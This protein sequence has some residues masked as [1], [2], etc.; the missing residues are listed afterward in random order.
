MIDTPGNLQNLTVPRTTPETPPPGTGAL[1]TP[2]ILYL[3]QGGQFRLAAAFAGTGNPTTIWQAL[4]DD[5]A[6]GIVYM[7]ELETKDEDVADAVAE[8]KL[9]VLKREMNV[10]PGDDSSQAAEIAAFVDTQIK[11]LPNWRNTLDTMLDAPYYGYSITEQIFDESSGQVS[12]VDLRDCPQELFS[13]APIG[14]PQVGQL[15][16]SPYMGAQG[17]VVPEQKFVTFSSRPRAGN[18]KGRGLLREVFWPSWFKR[19]AQRFWL[20]YCEKGPGTVVTKYRE[21]A[22]P[23]EKAQALAAAEAIFYA[24]AVAVPENFSIE[25]DLLTKARAMNPD[26]YE[27]LYSILEQ[28]IF[29]RIVGSTL[30]SHGSDGGK[31]SQAQGNVHAATKDE[32]SVEHTLNLEAVLNQQVVRQLVWWNYGPDAPMPRLSFDIS[33]EE[34]LGERITVDDTAAQM[35]LPISV[36]YMREKY[37][38]PAPIDDE[39]TLI[40][41]T[42]P[43]PPIATPAGPPDKPQFA[44]TT[45]NA[46]QQAQ[47]DRDVS[48][49]DTLMEQM[50]AEGKAIYA[51]RVEELAKAHLAQR[52]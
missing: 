7:R 15:R 35:G 50:S 23:S 31:G 4:I 26:A 28:K 10:L 34:D 18:R 2:E 52:S 41:P 5:Q 11:G 25:L 36:A 27:K 30:T 19:N 47:V 24:T 6:M 45:G 17:T 1:V 40:R 51:R 21:G 22:E 13:F 42:A 8:M 32:R 29:R 37:G 44:A 16:L 38:L 20:Q 46:V 3:N 9:S 49:F 12:L 39:D 33:N 14:Y 43:A 48:A